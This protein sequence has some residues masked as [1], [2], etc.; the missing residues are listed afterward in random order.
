MNRH[1]IAVALFAAVLAA[2]CTDTPERAA[3][4]PLFRV[5]SGFACDFRSTFADARAYFPQDRQRDI[6]VLI[7][8]MQ[9]AY[10]GGN[11]AGATDLGFDVMVAVAAVTGAGQQSGTPTDGSNLTNDLIACMNVGVSAPIDF[12]VSLTLVGGYQVRGGS[13][14][15]ESPVISGDGF[16]GVSAPAAVSFASWL[17]GRTLFYGRPAGPPVTNEQPVGTAYDWSTVPARHSGLNGQGIV[18]LCIVN[19]GRLRVQENTSILS[20][21]NPTFLSCAG[22]LANASS[23]PTTLAQ[24]ATQLVLSV[25][26]PQPLLATAL[27]DGGTGGNAEGFS[28]FGVVDA[29][30][31]N[32]DF[33]TQPVDAQAFAIMAPVRV[34]ARG[35]GGTPLPAVAVTIAVAGNEGSWN[36]S[37]TFTRIT[38]AD[39]IATFDDL[40]LDK[41]GGYTFAATSSAAG[42]AASQVISQAFHINF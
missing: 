37:G 36:F 22:F 32:L 24:R 3:T 6:Q 11:T 16:S 39:G 2:A 27:E 31:V 29:G 33:F 7:K 8:Q 14:D 34:R 18:G 23:R 4:A 30:S 28:T 35:N 40:S 21:A 12:N 20:P 26:R 15:P 1:L 17:G 5:G 42:F 10:D 9:S 38:G 25:L 19:P 41:P 13:F